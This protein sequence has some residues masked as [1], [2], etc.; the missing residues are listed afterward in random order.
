MGGLLA[1]IYGVIAY[2]IFLVTFLYA[3]GFVGNLA[4]P[5]SIDSG[6]PD[7]LIESL[8]VNVALLG[9]FAVQICKMLGAN[10]IPVIGGKDK[11]PLVQSLGASGF[12]VLWWSGASSAARPWTVAAGD[13][14][15]GSETVRSACTR[16]PG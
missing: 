3:I 8:L 7:P 5:K 13:F 12:I 9:V 15:A 6:M 10:P 11:A 16:M 1:L 14:F 2:A 4:V